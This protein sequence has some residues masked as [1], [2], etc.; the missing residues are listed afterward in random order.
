[1][2]RSESN[3]V[4]LN[5]TGTYPDLNMTHYPDKI[6]T[7][8]AGAGYNPNLKG[9]ENRKDYNLAEHVNALGDAVMAVERVLGVTPYLD[10]DGVDRSTVSARIKTLEMVDLDPRYGGLG[11]NTTQTLV[12]HTHTGSP[13]GP[14]KISLTGEVTGVLPKANLNLNYQAAGGLTGSDISVSKEQS[15]TIDRSINDKLS[16]SQGGTIQKNL[17][18][19]GRFNTGFYAD[20]DA[21]Y[22][23]PN[24]GTLVGGETSTLSGSSVKVANPA[25]DR[26]FITATDMN[27]QFGRYIGI[28]RMKVTDN[29][30]NEVVVDLSSY[31][32]FKDHSLRRLEGK[33]EIKATDFVE[34]NKWQLF[35]FV[36]DVPS[37]MEVSVVRRKTATNYDLSFDY[38]HI[39]PAHPAIYDN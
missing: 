14:S 19:K 1:M 26:A 24:A 30:K 21:S 11:W 23:V 20:I 7:R 33:K 37:E 15:T 5:G 32:L 8:V 12:G 38:M 9:F 2:A 36:F 27:L 3:I 22:M 25:T 29:T 6:D 39:C 18:I 34:A 16:I 4:K 28:V 10:K 31:R 13:G 17:S 35:Y